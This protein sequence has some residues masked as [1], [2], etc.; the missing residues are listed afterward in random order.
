M[1]DDGKYRARATEWAL[2]RASTGKEQVAVQFQTVDPNSPDA[3]PGPRIT[4]YGYFTEGT[5]ERTVKALRTCGWTGS[6]LSD[7][8]GLDA[9]EVQL[10]IE[11]D[12][13]N[14]AISAKVKWINPVGGLALKE[15]LSPDEA[16]SFAQRMKGQVLA[17]GGGKPTAPARSVAGVAR[18]AA[19]SARRAVVPPEPPPPEDASAYEPRGQ[20]AGDDIP[21]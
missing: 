11:N 19:P 6:D 9:N 15:Q 8:Q 18:P 10:V 12:E 14:G 7:L 5:F 4:W 1:I 3:E 2:G 13:Y 20:A 17:L 21:F 16:R